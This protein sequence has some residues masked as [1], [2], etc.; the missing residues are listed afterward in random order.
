[1]PSAGIVRAVNPSVTSERSRTAHQ[2][3]AV[4]QPIAATPVAF[5]HTILRAYQKYG[6]DP[7]NALRLAHISPKD[8]ERPGTRLTAE[9]LEIF[10]GL[11]M[12]Q[13]KD[14]ALGWF[15]RKLPWGSYGMLCRAS[16]TAANLG[17]ALKRWCRHHALLTSDI[18]LALT[19]GNSTARITITEHRPLAELRELCLLTNLRNVY[20]YACWVVDERI[21]LKRVEFPFASP[22]HADLYP[23]LFR[24]AVHF[25]AAHTT[26]LF[27]ARYL[28]L[29]LRRDDRA[30]RSM[31]R[32]ALPLVVRQYRADHLLVQRSRAL[33]RTQ[34][35]ELRTAESVAN[36]L[37]VSLRTLHRRLRAE[38]ASLQQLKDE[39]RRDLA[40]ECMTR[41]SRPIKQIARD[42]GFHNEKSFMRAFKQ[43]T[44]ESPL[45]YRRRTTSR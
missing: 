28:T 18:A 19:V 25:G 36:A 14:E 31:L 34:S 1:M 12:C 27:D 32:N 16:L 9:Q 41:T 45:Q 2:P 35:K 13:L 10:T 3:R 6:V 44:G 42:V 8:L 15:S 26:L 38:G 21:S 30:L 5:V 11:A 17:I 40:A 43:W 29:P 39:V 22:S 7:R 23:L 37:N 33:L 4:R 24:G 20:G